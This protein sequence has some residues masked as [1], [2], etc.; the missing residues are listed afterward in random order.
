MR[1]AWSRSVLAA[2]LLG[3]AWSAAPAR[4]VECIA[5]VAVGG[6]CWFL[7]GTGQSCTAVCAAVGFPYDEATRTF[8]GSDGTDAHCAQVLAALGALGFP[9]FPIDCSP[10]GLGCVRESGSQ[11]SVRCT[12]PTTADAGESGMRA[13][14]CQAGGVS[15]P[16]LGRGGSAA[17]LGAI[18]AVAAWRLR[19][20]A[21]A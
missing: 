7:G 11:D 5:G 19:R 10:D 8:A 21:R 14:A 16:A 6:S 4:A 2:L 9:P 3:L 1:G 15:A 13:C 17:A 18:L 12:D 20:R